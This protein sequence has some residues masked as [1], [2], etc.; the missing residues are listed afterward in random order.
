ML[1]DA[2]GQPVYCGN[3]VWGQL[4][5]R[6]ESR[7]TPYGDL[8]TTGGQVYCQ[9][10]PKRGDWG[11]PKMEHTDHCSHHPALAGLT[12]NGLA[13]PDLPITAGIPVSDWLQGEC[14]ICDAK[15]GENC[16][17]EIRGHK[18][19]RTHVER[20]ET[21]WI[22]GLPECPH[23]GVAPGKKCVIPGGAELRAIHYARE[24]VAAD[25][26]M[27]SMHFKT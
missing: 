5:S 21:A 6:F 15:P 16:V 1:Y 18:E 2:G 12:V 8:Q 19:N 27:G 17:R 13:K 22:A 7:K 14:P 4:A 25:S 3:C 9:L 24:K 10:N 11:F 23:C 20:E 26:L